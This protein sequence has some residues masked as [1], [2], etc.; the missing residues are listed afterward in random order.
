MRASRELTEPGLATV[1]QQPPSKRAMAGVRGVVVVTYDA[2][3][4]NSADAILSYEYLRWF[5]GK[6]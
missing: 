5:L 1:M 3:E 2:A 6:E 4:C